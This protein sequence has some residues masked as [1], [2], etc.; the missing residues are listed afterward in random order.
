MRNSFLILAA[1]FGI[2]G[3]AAAS[4]KVEEQVFGPVG[5]EVKYSI[6]ERGVHL[7][8]VA[9]KGSRMNV[10]VDGVA[11]P[12]ADEIFA[13]VRAWIDPRNIDSKHATTA[14]GRHA[15]DQRS[16]EAVV[17]SKDGKR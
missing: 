12:K 8:S 17:F 13:T 3:V 14:S 11:G 1:S 4:P 10:I 5:Q 2:L 16:L 9:R 7:A 15:T 6:S